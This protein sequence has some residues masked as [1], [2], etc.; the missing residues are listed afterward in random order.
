MSTLK[1]NNITD[2]GDDAVVTSGVLDTLAVPAGGILQI[3]RATDTTN[4]T[5]STSSFADAGISVTITPSSVNSSL[6]LIWS[7]QA[8]SPASDYISIQIT[9]SSDVAISGAERGLI[10]DAAQINYGLLTQIGFVSPATTSPVTYKGRARTN[11]GSGV[12]LNE[13]CAG[14][15]IA[16]EVA[17]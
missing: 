8:H 14:Q 7:V 13:Q 9:D 5:F 6:M 2:L 4:R 1:V 11:G 17:G 16:I 12:L 15:L 3:V 10:G